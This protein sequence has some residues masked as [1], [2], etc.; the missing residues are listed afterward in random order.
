MGHCPGT[1]ALKLWGSTWGAIKVCSKKP[2]D[3][4]DL[5]CMP[6]AWNF[7]NVL[8]HL[9]SM[10]ERSEMGRRQDPAL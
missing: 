3:Q 7:L 2:G 8:A 5:G 6:Q 1:A 10:P 4:A 9:V